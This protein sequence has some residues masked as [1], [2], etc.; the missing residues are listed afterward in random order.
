MTIEISRRRIVGQGLAMGAFIGLVGAINSSA[1]TPAASPADAEWTWTDDRGVTVTLPH[2]PTKIIAQ[3]TAAVS[4]AGF[5]VPIAGHF[6]S[7]DPRQSVAFPDDNPIDISEWVF[8]GPWGEFDIEAALS[9]DA[10]LYVDL[11]RGEGDD[12]WGLGD[13]A[14]R[15]PGKPLRHRSP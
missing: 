1:Q 9:T 4:L 2:R 3:S 14:T 12:F 6:G 13:P 11:Y 8:L 15:P 5:G 10:E 7:E